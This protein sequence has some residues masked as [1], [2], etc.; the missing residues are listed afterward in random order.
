MFWNHVLHCVTILG[1]H[2]G[3]DGSMS[4]V[5]LCLLLTHSER[6]RVLFY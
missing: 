2:K 6:G 3:K 4:R 1:G 5:L